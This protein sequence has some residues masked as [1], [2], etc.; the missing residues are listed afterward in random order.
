V[1]AIFFPKSLSGGRACHR[2]RPY[3]AHRPTCSFSLRYWPEAS[4]FASNPQ[5]PF[6]AT[7]RVTL[8]ELLLERR[9]DGTAA[10]V[11]DSRRSG[12]GLLPRRRV[13]RGKAEEGGGAREGDGAE[14]A[15]TEEGGGTAEGGGT[16]GV[17][18]AGVARC[19]KKVI[20]SPV[21][22]DLAAAGI[23]HLVDGDGSSSSSHPPLFSPTGSSTRPKILVV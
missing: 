1:C 12:A 20:Q 2:P 4:F 7:H 19:L 3:P 22:Q 14:D 5:P 10:V 18:G 23:G 6:L 9:G 13:D 16:C 21:A 15:L 8:R 17:P 11:G